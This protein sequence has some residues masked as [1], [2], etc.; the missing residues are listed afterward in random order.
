V[1]GE[2][3]VHGEHVH[4]VLF[5]DRMHGIVTSDLTLVIWV[6]QVTFL[7]IRPDLLYRLWSR[8]SRL[9]KHCC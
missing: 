9:P 2:Q 4:F 1:A 6:L 5:E 8:Q 3:L 7:D